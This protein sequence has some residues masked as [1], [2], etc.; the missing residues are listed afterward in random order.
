VSKR[1]L[2]LT[3][4]GVKPFFVADKNK[5][6]ELYADAL[7]LINAHSVVEHPKTGMISVCRK[8]HIIRQDIYKLIMD[9]EIKNKYQLELKM[10]DLGLLFGYE[11]EDIDAFIANPPVCSCPHCN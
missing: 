2:E 11:P 1:D 7:K 9:R 4:L 10:W 5:E 3:I 8:E 6:P